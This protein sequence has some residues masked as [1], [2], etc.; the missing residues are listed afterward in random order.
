MQKRVGSLC[1]G[2]GGFDLGLERAGYE[3]AWQV[4]IDNY[5][6]KVLQ[7]HWPKVQRYNDIKCIDW[8]RVPPVDLVCAGFPCQPF[9][10][11]GK[12]RGKDDDRY[13]WSEIARC[14][15]ILRPAWFLGENV[16]GIINLALDQVCADL[17][18]LG[19]TVWPVCIPACAVDAPHIRQRVWI[20]AHTNGNGLEKDSDETGL[21]DTPSMPRFSGYFGAVGCS[22]EWTK[23]R[24]LGA[25]PMGMGNGIPHG[26][27]RLRGLGNAIVPQIAE[28]L[29]RMILATE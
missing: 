18:S 14:L 26:V 12:R 10:Q 4:E 16:P 11:A 6:Q 23:P 25:R 1:S 24:P 13:L 5:C 29:G 2:I 21:C 17:E 9:S 28:V 19:Y 8:H 27:D 3:I 15:T 22:A 20:L 7:K